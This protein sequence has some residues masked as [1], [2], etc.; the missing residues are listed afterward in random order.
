MMFSKPKT[1]LPIYIIIAIIEIP[2]PDAVVSIAIMNQ[3][4]KTF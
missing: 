2:I 3:L 4:I 1:G